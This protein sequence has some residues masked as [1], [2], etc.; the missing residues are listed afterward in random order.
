MLSELKDKLGLF[1][2]K[3]AIIAYIGV[4]A[5]FV[6]AGQKFSVREIL[7]SLGK[8]IIV[9]LIFIVFYLVLFVILPLFFRWIYHLFNISCLYRRVENL[10]KK[11]EKK[12]K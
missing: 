3:N 6:I 1:K 5:A 9:I 7:Y 12:K 8:A 4:F 11:V 10:E 2:D